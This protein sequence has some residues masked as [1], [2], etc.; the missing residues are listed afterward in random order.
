MTGVK[1]TTSQM[2][3][4]VR[5]TFLTAGLAVIAC[6]GSTNPPPPAKAAPV[7]ENSEKGSEP[8]ATPAKPAAPV[9]LA[10]GATAPALEL[11]AADGS[12][13]KLADALAAGPV[14]LVF[15]RGHW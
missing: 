3:Q 8:E 6:S 7:A 10:V 12:A 14:V 2:N 1:F 9:G 11:P 15:Y 5:A 4:F 13:F